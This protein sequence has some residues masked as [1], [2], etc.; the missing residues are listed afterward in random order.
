[1]ARNASMMAELGL[2]PGGAAVAATAAAPLSRPENCMAGSALPAP[3]TPSK[4]SKPKQQQQ[5]QQLHQ[6]HGGGGGRAS[7]R[8]R[9]FLEVRLN[10]LVQSDDSS[11]LQE[12]VSQL[13]AG[14]AKRAPFHANLAWLVGLLREGRRAAL[15]VV[16]V[17]DE[18]DRFAERPKQKLLYNLFDLMQ[19]PNVQMA[20]VGLTS[21]LDPVD[22]LEKRIKSRFS[23]RQIL[24]LP[25]TLEQTHASLLRLLSLPTAEPAHRGYAN[26]SNARVGELL[27]SP[28]FRRL[29]GRAHRWGMSM[30]YFSRWALAAVAALTFAGERDDGAAG[31]GGVGGGGGSG[32]SGGGSGGGGGSSSG[33]GAGTQQQQQQQQQQGASR[34]EF[35]RLGHF[36]RAHTLV[37]PPSFRQVLGGISM[38]EVCLLIAMKRL[39]DHEFATYNFQMAYAEYRKFVTGEEGSMSVH[40]YVKRVGFKA[41]EHLVDIEL[42][43]Y[44][45]SGNEMPL[46]DYRMVVMAID[47]QTLLDAVADGTLKCSTE[48][49][50]WA[51]AVMAV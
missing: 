35:L 11:A 2:V 43:K 7:F 17:L 24:L 28:A 47:G 39:E 46:P 37:G 12:A 34:D 40:N 20:V 25:P 4:P 19:Q 10:G 33:G 29:S 14:R 15:P 31:V 44:V 36:E 13:S 16:F 41:F 3:R 6:Q 48:I 23:N 22:L 21:R 42:L 38:P 49:Q 9:A 51:T 50:R 1:M 32:G 30:R 8:E 27:R 26:V 18:F 5:R 45:D